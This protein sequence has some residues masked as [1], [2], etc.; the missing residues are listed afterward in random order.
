MLFQPLTA[1]E[2]GAVVER[3]RTALV[4]GQLFQPELDPLVN[5]VGVLGLNLGDDRKA[6]AATDQRDD[7][8]GADGSQDGV[9]FEVAQAEAALDDLG[10][11][12]IGRASC[13]E[14]V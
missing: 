7:P 5:V 10:T 9:S 13:R 14:R 12:E 1:G 4:L 8:P 6:G 3:D 2:L 11:V